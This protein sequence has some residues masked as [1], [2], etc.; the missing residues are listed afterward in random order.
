MASTILVV[1]DEVLVR[2]AVADYLRHCGYRVL[3]AKT[4]EEAQAI[5]RAG[6]RVEILFCD[7][8]LG[9]GINGF[10]LAKWTRE[11]YGDMRILLTSGVHRTAQVA[12]DL[13]DGP[14]L[15]KPY[16]YDVLAERIGKLLGALGKRM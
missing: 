5:L 12:A 2:L 11:H 16:G 13:C 10:E 4:G 1:E 9:P 6:E 3:E 14:L 8:D 15:T 7:I